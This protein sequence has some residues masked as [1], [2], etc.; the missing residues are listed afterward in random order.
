MVTINNIQIVIVVQ[1]TTF[2]YPH[3]LLFAHCQTVCIFIGH[4]IIR[5]FVK[6]S[7]KIGTY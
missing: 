2:Y 6:T 1:L 4:Y 7:Q 5:Q 3:E